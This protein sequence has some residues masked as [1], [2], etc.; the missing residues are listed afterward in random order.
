MTKDE[1]NRLLAL[2]SEAG[3]LWAG[4]CALAVLTAKVEQ[5]TPPTPKLVWGDDSFAAKALA[6]K[7]AAQAAQLASRLDPVAITQEAGAP[8]MAK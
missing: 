4:L 7:L 1:Q 5:E 2:Q 3:D 8:E 6:E